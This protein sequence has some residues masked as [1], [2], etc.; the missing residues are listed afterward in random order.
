MN[1]L[2]FSK[3][4]C[5]MCSLWKK[6]FQKQKNKTLQKYEA[7]IT[8]ISDDSTRTKEIAHIKNILDII[9]NL[10][11][12]VVKLENVHSNRLTTLTSTENILYAKIEP[13]N[14]SYPKLKDQ[15]AS[16]TYENVS[17]PGHIYEEVEFDCLKDRR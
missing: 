12:E 17:D 14:G 1:S 8:V 3:K 4:V 2:E 11:D 6:I 13:V 15:E 16:R 7:E 5:K 10:K 9:K